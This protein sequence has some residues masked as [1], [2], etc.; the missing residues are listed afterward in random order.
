MTITMTGEFVKKMDPR[1]ILEFVERSPQFLAEM[2]REESE[3]NAQALQDRIRQIDYVE[4]IIKERAAIEM[5]L[6][7]QQPLTD[8][9]HDAWVE[10]AAKTEKLRHRHRELTALEG[11]ACGGLLQHGEAA[12]DEACTRLDSVVRFIARTVHSLRGNPPTIQSEMPMYR[13]KI[14]RFI[15]YHRKAQDAFDRANKLRMARVPPAELEALAADL[16]AV[17]DGFRLGDDE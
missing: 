4:S 3:A 2:Q 6:E 9:A 13:A 14:E 5:Q 15:G 7:K 11:A 1:K 17:V 10:Q 8:K 12:I 16:L